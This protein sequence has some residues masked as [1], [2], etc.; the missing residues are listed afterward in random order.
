MAVLTLRHPETSRVEMLSVGNVRS[1]ATQSRVCALHDSR[2]A[3]SSA[4][5][6]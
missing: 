6:R 5:L 2:S 4:S 3:A 1:A